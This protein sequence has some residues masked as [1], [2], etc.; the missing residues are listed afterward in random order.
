MGVLFVLCQNCFSYWGSHINFRVYLSLSVKAIIG[1]LI[2]IALDLYIALD[3]IDILTIW[4]SSA[5]TLEVFQF[6]YIIFSFFQWCLAVFTG[7]ES[8]TSFLLRKV[9]PWYCILFDVIVDGI[10]FRIVCVDLCHVWRLWG[11]F[12]YCNFT[13]FIIKF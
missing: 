8:F 10:V 5:W 9:I 11:D 7:Y 2:Q 13:E 6:I 1:L 3:S 4:S 12:V